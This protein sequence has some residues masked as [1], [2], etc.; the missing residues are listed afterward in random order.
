MQKESDPVSAQYL[1]IEDTLRGTLLKKRAL[2]SLHITEYIGEKIVML[3]R[4]AI[5]RAF[6]VPQRRQSNPISPE[7]AR[8]VL[9]ELQNIIKGGQGCIE[10]RERTIPELTAFVDACG[11]VNEAHAVPNVQRELLHLYTCQ[12]LKYD[13]KT[14]RMKITGR[15]A[16]TEEPEVA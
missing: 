3:V 4:D 10:V 8:A 5:A 15:Q 12:Q 7:R 13:R 14:G 1:K 11:K 6:E 9:T 2:Q 16:S